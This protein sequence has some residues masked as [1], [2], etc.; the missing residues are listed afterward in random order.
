MREIFKWRK[1]R[2]SHILEL[3]KYSYKFSGERKPQVYIAYFLFL[4]RNIF[5]QADIL[6]VGYLFNI[7][8]T[9]GITEGNINKI[10]LLLLSLLIIE[11]IFWVTHAP[12]RVLEEYNGQYASNAFRK[13]L[14]VNTLALPLALHN[15]EHSGK[16]ISRISKGQQGLYSFWSNFS[17]T[18]KSVSQTLVVLIALLIFDYRFAIAGIII[19]GITTYIITFFDKK[20]DRAGDEIE[21]IDNTISAI[22]YDTI[23]NITTI[24]ML[25]LS[26]LINS[27]LDKEVDLQYK[28]FKNRAINIELKWITPA[29]VGKFFIVGVLLYYVNFIYI[30]G[31]TLM[32]G[33]L[34]TLYG[35]LGRL[36]YSLFDLAQILHKVNRDY[37]GIKN[38]K[39]LSGNFHLIDN[40]NVQQIT[41]IQSIELSNLHFKYSEAFDLHVDHLKLEKGKSYAFVGESGCG[42]TTMMKILA[43][44]VEC[45]GYEMRVAPLPF[46]KGMGDGMSL[47]NIRDSI[48]LIPQEPELFSNSIRENITLGLPYSEREVNDVLDMVNMRETVE[49]L[50]EG[51]ESKVY[52]KGVNLSG[53]QKQR[54]E[55]ARGILFARDKEIILLDE[56]TS[57]VDQDNEEH[58]YKSL[59][60]L[61]KEKILIS[62]VH[63][64]NLLTMFDHIVYFEKGRI[65][66]VQ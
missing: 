44:L 57:S 9:E 43:S 54:L 56:P 34:Y 37:L 50:P 24:K 33:T 52:E 13:Y 26:A 63:K 22:V 4:L 5:D 48:M 66:K 20:I 15:E 58:I 8:Q 12:G 42:K 51:I 17:M 18:F 29:L 64:R 39:L 53:G 14:Y 60:N 6:V 23:A 38:S 36:H 40:K 7:M 46:G 30:S 62:S 45:E 41:N 59:L 31:A 1:K 3:L 2:N 21:K 27:S 35:F 16:I 32:I 49:E 11:I 65:T 47:D 10:L 61:S 28:I 25:S 55:L 19:F